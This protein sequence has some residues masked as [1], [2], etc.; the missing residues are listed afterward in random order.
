MGA[1]GWKIELGRSPEGVVG[2]YTERHWTPSFPRR[3]LSENG[4]TTMP[5]SFHRKM[6]SIIF[7]YLLGSNFRW[8]DEN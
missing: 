3:S 6:E 2:R 7:N 5:S 1:G 8:S 4:K